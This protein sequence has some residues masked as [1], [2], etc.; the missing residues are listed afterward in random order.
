MKTMPAGELDI[1]LTTKMAELTTPDR[2]GRTYGYYGHMHRPTS[3]AAWARAA[4]FVALSDT[5]EIA[6][7]DI[8]LPNETFDNRVVGLNLDFSRENWTAGTED[9]ELLAALALE[10][11]AFSSSSLAMLSPADFEPSGRVI[12]GVGP[13]DY[14]ALAYLSRLLLQLRLARDEETPLLLA[15]TDQRILRELADFIE[16]EEIPTP[17][18]IPDLRTPPGVA[19]PPE[20]PLAVVNLNAPGIEN[21]EAVKRDKTVQRYI[22]KIRPLLL[23]PQT[24]ESERQ[25]VEAL[26][27]AYGTS[28]RIQ[29]AQTVFEVLGWI[30]KPLAAFGAT[31]I[32]SGMKFWLKRERTAQ[33]W[34]LLGPRMNEIA[35]KDYLK[36]KENY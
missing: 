28:K 19:L 16:R 32:T 12:D 34:F 36:R 15:D 22:R 14:F 11:Q 9:A 5:T 33:E 23:G 31:I 20:F 13:V 26:R 4:T 21:I 35:I 29:D 24:L 25:G 7:A 3:E 2:V 6:P 30:A 8:G 1:A 27:E 10:G 17:F 18:D